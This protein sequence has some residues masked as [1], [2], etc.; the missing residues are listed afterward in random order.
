MSHAA[1]HPAGGHGGSA[2]LP[3]PTPLPELPSG[4]PLVDRGLVMAWFAASLFWTILAPVFGLLAAAK[5][6]DP[7]LLPDVEWLQ[8][9]P[10]VELGRVAPDW[11]LSTLHSSMNWSAGLGIRAWASG[12]V[13]RVDIAL[14]EEG[15]GVQMMIS[16]PFQ[17]L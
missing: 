14:S 2:A 12:F 15:S 5:L 11:N 17:F 10:F 7:V 4:Q 8:F 3:A 16:Q 13:L 6:D 9:V 1:S